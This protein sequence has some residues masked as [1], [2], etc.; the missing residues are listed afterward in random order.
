MRNC[1]G[2]FTFITL[3]R[4]HSKPV[5]QEVDKKELTTNVQKY[6]SREAAKKGIFL[7]KD[8]LN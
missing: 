7:G 5:I 4:S 1:V 2:Y 8:G 3:F 6:L